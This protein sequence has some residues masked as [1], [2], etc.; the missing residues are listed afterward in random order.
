MDK[1]S[2]LEKMKIELWRVNS[3]DMVLQACK[4]KIIENPKSDFHDFS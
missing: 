1:N 3:L 4:F 2:R